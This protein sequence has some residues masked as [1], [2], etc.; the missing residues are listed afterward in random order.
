MPDREQVRLHAVIEGRVQGVGFRYFVL[1][2]ALPLK[3]TGWVR[4]TA[5]GQVEFIA[6]GEQKSLVRLLDTVR[7]GPRAAF[8]SAINQEWLPAT[9][10]F[11]RFDI[12]G[13]V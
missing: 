10:E 3:V 4:N 11:D 1:E 12:R 6:E 13:T 8:V 5:D 7:H 2:A 9:Q